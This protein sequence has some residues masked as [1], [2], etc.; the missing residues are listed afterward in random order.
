MGREV[1]AYDEVRS[2]KEVKVNDGGERVRG[3]SGRMACQ[4][5]AWTNI[6]TTLTTLFIPAYLPLSQVFLVFLVLLVLFEIHLPSV[7]ALVLR[8]GCIRLHKAGQSSTSHA[9]HTAA[10]LWYVVGI[11]GIVGILSS[12]AVFTPVRAPN[13]GDRGFTCH[14]AIISIACGCENV[15]LLGR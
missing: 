14:Q 6:G 4:P 12:L 11:V 3:A 2:S 1:P 7:S 15:G 9:S 8:A 10:E 13:N 5:S